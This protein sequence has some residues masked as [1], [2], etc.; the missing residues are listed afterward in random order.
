M[1][2][3]VLI[4][5]TILGDPVSWPDGVIPPS[6]LENPGYLESDRPLWLQAALA[7]NRNAAYVHECALRPRLC[8]A[9]AICYACSCFA[10]STPRLPCLRCLLGWAL[11]KRGCRLVAFAALCVT[12]AHV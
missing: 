2:Y 7:A 3:E 11:E 9:M 10:L 4:A 12:W 8:V 6:P 1:V 5:L